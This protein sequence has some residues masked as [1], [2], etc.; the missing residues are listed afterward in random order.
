MG[1]PLG[2][3]T[4]AFIFADGFSYFSGNPQACMNCHIMKPNFDA[5]T[6]STHRAVATCNDCHTSGPL[7]TKYFQ[8]AVN[9]L[10]HSWAFTS[11]RFHEPIQIKSFNL[12]IT[13]KSCLGCHQNLIDSSHFG[14]L[15]FGTKNCTSCH[16]NVGHRRW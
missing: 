16:I 15:G 1:A 6:A 14:A 7:V 5:W 2:V 9:G 8:K 11:G 4:G 3:S 13:K 12:E 10:L